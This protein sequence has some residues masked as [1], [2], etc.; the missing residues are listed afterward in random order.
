MVFIFRQYNCRRPPISLLACPQQHSSFWMKLPLKRISVTCRNIKDAGTFTK[1]QIVATV[2]FFETI[3]DSSFKPLHRAFNN[4]R[5]DVCSSLPIIS[6]VIRQKRKSQ[7]G[8]FKKT[9][10]AKFSEK[11]NISHPLICTRTCPYQGVRN[12][13]FSENLACSVFLKHPFWDS[14]FCLI[15]DDIIWA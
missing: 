12:V 7:N 10:H 3:F 9:K 14:P 1:Y 15:T 4:G 11:K 6:S 13:R 5:R 8:C 2:S